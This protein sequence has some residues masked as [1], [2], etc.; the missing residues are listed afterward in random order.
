MIESKTFE[1]GIKYCDDF[2]MV[3][4]GAGGDLNEWVEGIAGVLKEENIVSKD[5]DT[6]KEAY[7]LSDNVN[8]SEGRCDLV[9][10]FSEDAQPVIGKLAMWRLAFGD[11][12]WID[13][14]CDNYCKDYESGLTY[15]HD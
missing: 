13:D 5:F 15:S 10:I 1:N 4:M 12:S 8:G 14:F 6:F 3:I 7:T 11:I 2:G 9:L